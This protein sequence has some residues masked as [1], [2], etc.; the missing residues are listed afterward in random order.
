MGKPISSQ[1]VSEIKG[2]ASAEAPG[3]QI[4]QGFQ[5]REDSSLSTSRGWPERCQYA[6]AAG[7]LLHLDVLA[8]ISTD[9]GGSCSST[10]KDRHQT[11]GHQQDP[12]NPQPPQRPWPSR[13]DCCAAPHHPE[14]DSTSRTRVLQDQRPGNK[15]DGHQPPRC[16]CTP[17]I[18]RKKPG[19]L[20]RSVEVAQVGPLTALPAVEAAGHEKAGQG[21]DPQGVRAR[22]DAAPAG[23]GDSTHLAPGEGPR[24]QTRD[25][26][27]HRSSRIRRGRLAEAG[28]I[29]HG[30]SSPDGSLL[31]GSGRRACFFK[32]VGPAGPSGSTCRKCPG[33]GGRQH[34]E[35]HTAQQTNHGKY[36]A[37]NSH[38][39]WA[40]GLRAA[41][42]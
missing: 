36:G 6:Q 2:S 34:L 25:T 5:G 9:N 38:S 4:A 22:G 23:G 12:A 29:R 14:G 1:L 11:V 31:V 30:R 10:W 19:E 33:V 7:L 35:A 3:Q 41:A 20:Q 13:G 37:A 27:R 24:C 39:A 32:R 18:N 42:S 40:V 21:R 8:K 16:R 17:A 26:K 28:D 15:R